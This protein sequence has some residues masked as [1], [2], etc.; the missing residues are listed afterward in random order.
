MRTS[1]EIDTALRRLG[2]FLRRARPAIESPRRRWQVVALSSHVGW[3][4]DNL[5]DVR[6]LVRALEE[7]EARGR[8]GLDII[9]DGVDWVCVEV[10]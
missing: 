9:W 8:R 5:A 4:C 2:Y 10:E 1:T 7:R 3:D 6:S